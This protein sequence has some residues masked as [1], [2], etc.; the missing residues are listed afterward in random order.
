[1]ALAEPAAAHTSPRPRVQ[2]ILRGER[3]E[4]DRV[5]AEL[6]AGD[7]D[8]A[9]SWQ[10]FLER[11]FEAILERALEAGEVNLPAAHPFWGAFTREQG[12][13]ILRALAAIGY[14]FDGLGGWLD[15]RVPTKRDLSIAVG[16]AGL[17]PV[18]IRS[19]PTTAEMATLLSQVQIAGDEYLARVAPQLSETELEPELRGRAGGVEDLVADW[20]RVRALLLAES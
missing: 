5:V 18:R 12:R 4:F 14:R 9:V 13:Q 6:S 3:A 10:R 8:R 17:D 1:M 7:S 15:D 2:R 11:F 20:G 19:W 16:Y